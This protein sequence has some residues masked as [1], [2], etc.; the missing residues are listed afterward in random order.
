MP[1][2][3]LIN[4]ELRKIKQELSLKRTDFILKTYP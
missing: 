1:E 4:N 3:T 2:N